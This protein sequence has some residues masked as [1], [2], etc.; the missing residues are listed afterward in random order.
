MLGKHASSLLFERIR[1][2]MGLVYGIGATV[3]NVEAFNTLS[4]GT[5]SKPDNIG[6]IEKV[7]K[8]II[9]DLCCSKISKDRLVMAKASMLGS[10]RMLTGS[11]IGIN[12]IVAPG[13]LKGDSE[14]MYKRPSMEIP[15]VTRGESIAQETFKIKPYI[16]RLWPE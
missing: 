2:E 1:E 6:L 13:Y 14:N 10:I 15:K 3:L 7:I 5:S 4:V 9:E 16:G 8:E 11:P 12:Q